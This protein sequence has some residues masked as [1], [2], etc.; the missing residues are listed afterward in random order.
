MN[1]NKW[2]Y[3][4]LRLSV[5]TSMFGH[6]LVRLPKLTAFSHWMVGSFQKSFL[7]V[8]LVTPFSYLLPVAEFVIGLMLI[9]GLFTKQALIAGGLVM[10]LLIFGTTMIENWDA[11]PV[12]LIHSAFFATLLHFSD[13]NTLAL[14]NLVKKK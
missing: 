8:E 4:L 5:G 1:M 3:L 9:I 11:I 7:P 14:N 2:T 6:G 12:Q 10:V 13:S